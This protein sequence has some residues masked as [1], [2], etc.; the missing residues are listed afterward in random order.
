MNDVVEK[1]RYIHRR[2]PLLM[3]PRIARVVEA[4][5]R[6][7]PDG[8]ST[9]SMEKPKVIDT[10]VSHL[11]ENADSFLALMRTL[12]KKHKFKKLVEDMTDTA[13][14]L[15]SQIEDT[16]KELA[17]L[18]ES[19]EEEMPGI[20]ASDLGE[21]ASMIEREGSRLS[22]IIEL[23]R[24]LNTLAGKVNKEEKTEPVEHEM[25]PKE[26]KPGDEENEEEEEKPQ[27]DE[28]L[29]DNPGGAGTPQGTPTPADLDQMFST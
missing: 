12:P 21:L 6:S 11:H 10:P 23:T 5:E 1:L 16:G 29:P 15:K 2:A 27:A 19:D 26:M 28:P 3:Q 24:T 20:K 7:F 17:K 22:D 14:S 8:V 25:P 9:P 18:L 4:I 13:S